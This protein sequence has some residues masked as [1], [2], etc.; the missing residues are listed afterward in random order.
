MNSHLLCRACVFVLGF[1]YFANSH[2]LAYNI[3]DVGNL[4]EI[5]GSRGMDVNAGRQVVGFAFFPERA[6]LYD[7]GQ[8]QDLGSLDGGAL[9]FA[10]NDGS[11]VTG[12]SGR[13]FL[14]DSVNGMQDLGTLGGSGSIGRGIN[15]TGKIV[16]WSD[17]AD[18]PGQH[19]FLWDSVDGMQDL[20]TLGDIDFSVALDV[21]DND[22]VTGLS[23]IEVGVSHAF[24]WDRVN[25][26]QDLGAL[27][28]DSSRGLGINNSG[29]IT[30]ATTEGGV[31]RAFLWDSVNG[32]Q[33]LG[34]LGGD[35]SLGSDINNRSQVVG[36]AEDSSGER[37]A[38]LYDGDSML[39]LC[40]LSN[41]I[42]AGWENLFEATGINDRGDIAGSG[43][44]N[45][46]RHAFLATVVPLPNAVWLFGSGLIGLLAMAKRR[47][48]S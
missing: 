44:I 25:G 24:L 12:E 26:M 45:G 13:A 33:D 23:D 21:N 17:I 11:Q 22:Q 39:D 5:P 30:G 34:T 37:Q 27:G 9:A 7:G 47:V 36:Y 14:W 15:N 20:G 6:F 18:G 48:Q 42:D 2:A 46:E 19:A 3:Y 28:G 31:D 35:S 29:Q 4:D 41:C 1:A 40:V 32:V 43:L 38:F 8:M 10:I 16:G